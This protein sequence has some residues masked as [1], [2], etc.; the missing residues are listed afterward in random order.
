[1]AIERKVSLLFAV[2]AV[3][4]WFVSLPGIVDPAFTAAAFGGVAPNYPSVVRS[5]TPFRVR[6]S[7]R[8]KN[9]E[10]LA[11]ARSLGAKFLSRLRRAKGSPEGCSEI[12][13]CQDKLDST[14]S[15]EPPPLVLFTH[16][17][18]LSAYET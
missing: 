13:V 3:I 7:N 8:V 10:W 16:H 2:N 12:S 17:F 9:P 6:F 4:N 14:V 11:G 1:M 18:A 5:S 15:K